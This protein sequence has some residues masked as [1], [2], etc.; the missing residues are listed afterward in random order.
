MYTI[1]LSYT[2]CIHS[3]RVHYAAVMVF[4]I[5]DTES[6]KNNCSF[7]PNPNLSVT[8]FFV[9]FTLLTYLINIVLLLQPV[10][11]YNCE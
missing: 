10:V 3:C 7:F 2:Q 5:I 11:L 8:F 6:S 9:I 4:I 1:Q